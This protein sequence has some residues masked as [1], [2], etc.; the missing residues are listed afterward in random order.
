MNKFLFVSALF[1][2]NFAYSEVLTEALVKC[3]MAKSNQAFYRATV[4]QERRSDSSGIIVFQN[5]IAEQNCM[6]G[7]YHLETLRHSFEDEYSMIPEYKAAV[8]LSYR[9]PF[10]K[11]RDFKL[12]QTILF[13]CE[14]KSAEADI[15]DMSF[16]GFF[17][18]RFIDSHAE[19][20]CGSG[21]YYRLSSVMG[22]ITTITAR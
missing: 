1:L 3:P 6:S 9:V 8:K 15:V 2:C 19:K 22:S 10:Q 4:K 13:E 21:R 11:R 16:S 7:G 14:G 20:K 17:S 5:E 12:G 18:L